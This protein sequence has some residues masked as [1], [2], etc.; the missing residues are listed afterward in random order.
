M[1]WRDLSTWEGAALICAPGLGG[2][3]GAAGL[4]AL[5]AATCCARNKAGQGSE[6]AAGTLSS[7]RSPSL[8]ALGRGFCHFPGNL[9]HGG[10]AG[11]PLSPAPVAASP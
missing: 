1:S 9:A 8:G 4:A 10:T 5:P 3:F 7:T 2:R 6:R 11:V